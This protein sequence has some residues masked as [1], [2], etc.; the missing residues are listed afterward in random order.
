MPP[1]CPKKSRR[2]EERVCRS[3][4]VGIAAGYWCEDEAPGVGT[5]LAPNFTRGTASR[6]CLLARKLFWRK[7]IPRGSGYGVGGVSAR[8][9]RPGGRISRVTL[10]P[11]SARRDG[12]HQ[13]LAR[14]ATSPTP[15]I[16]LI[17]LDLRV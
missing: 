11:H 8:P 6:E 10:M 5:P 9:L 2:E 3:F 7:E 14:D 16:S 13:T 12:A 1:R 4:M 17:T 15:R